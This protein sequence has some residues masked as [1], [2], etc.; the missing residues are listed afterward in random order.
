MLVQYALITDAVFEALDS[1]QVVVRYGIGV[2]NV[3]L[4][5]ATD[6]GVAV[7]NVPDYCLDVVPEHALALAFTCE[8]KTA[9]YDER[10]AEGTWD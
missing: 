5:S 1:L 4:E 7:T 10:I 2:N 9:L 8:R 6:H 3:D